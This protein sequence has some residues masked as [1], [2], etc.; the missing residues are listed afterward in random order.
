MI[1]KT[2]GFGKIKGNRKVGFVAK[3]SRVK[4]WLGCFMVSTLGWGSDDVIN[5][6]LGVLSNQINNDIGNVPGNR[7]NANMSF[8]YYKNPN[9]VKEDELEARFTFA[10]L[11]N[12]RSLFMYSVQEAY[13]GGKLTPRND[14]KI[15]RQNLDWSTV[16]QTWGFGKL[17]N[18]RNFDYFEPGQEGLVGLD[19]DFKADNGI[20]IKTFVTPLYIPE[21]NPAFDINNSKGT[22][23]SRNPWSD[24]PASTAEI[25]PGNVARI[26]YKVDYPSVSDV[27]FR[28]AA[29]IN[30][31]YQNKHWLMD[32]FYMRKPE[33]GLTTKV[34]VAVDTINNVINAKITPQVY[35]HDVYGTTLKYRNEDLQ[36]YFSAIAIRPND[37]PDGNRDATRYTTIKTE[38]RREDYVGGGLSIKKDKYTY[39]FN[40]VARLSPFDRDKE[41]LATDPRWNQAL[42]LFGTWDVTSRISLVGDLKVDMLT[43]DR[44]L[45][46]RAIY[47]LSRDFVGT[48]GM[49]LIGTPDDG[50][51]YW[52]TYTNNDSLF[53]GLRY[54]F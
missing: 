24:V 40:Y 31:G 12:D 37:Y 39:G 35:Y 36:M 25:S 42:N 34:E 48:F 26:N 10:G 43:T 18:R 32:N 44:L 15:G 9:K 29:G 6:H 33:N 5:G 38:K 41:E 54:V 28:P 8:D 51:S 11:V 30:L 4:L 13:L 23:R 7:Y 49:N 16:D 53:A 21:L 27:I 22:I 2:V 45:M 19:W 1:V 14:L 50:K 52:S 20:R 47:K 46:L 3:I 17:N